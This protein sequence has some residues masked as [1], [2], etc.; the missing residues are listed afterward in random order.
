MKFNFVVF[1]FIFLCSSITW[2]GGS[3]GGGEFPT[4]NSSVAA[5]GIAGGSGGFPTGGSILN[6]EVIVSDWVN[7]GGAG[8]GDSVNPNAVLPNLLDLSNNVIVGSSAEL[9]FDGFTKLKVIKGEPTAM[10]NHTIDQDDVIT[11][12]SQIKEKVLNVNAKMQYQMYADKIEAGKVDLLF[13]TDE[14]DKIILMDS[15]KIK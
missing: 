15:S 13:V 2:A 14:E 11:T 6:P 12:F 8:T 10:T 3:A 5:G 1:I 9:N 4:D 7:A